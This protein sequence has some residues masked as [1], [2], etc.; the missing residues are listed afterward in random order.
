MDGLISAW[1]KF[2]VLGWI[3]PALSVGIPVALKGNSSTSDEYLG[4]NWMPIKW[5]KDGHNSLTFLAPLVIPA[6]GGVVEFSQTLDQLLLEVRPL[7]FLLF[8]MLLTGG[9]KQPGKQ[10]QSGSFS[11]IGI[12]WENVYIHVGFVCIS[13]SAGGLRGIP[14]HKKYCTKHL[15][16]PIS[17]VWYC[18]IKMLGL[19]LCLI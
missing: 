16:V 12:V 11:N 8:L 18:I 1:N 6:L 13:Y 7:L 17:G 2:N 5:S 14:V 10:G 15:E 4:Q 3:L 19:V 9:M